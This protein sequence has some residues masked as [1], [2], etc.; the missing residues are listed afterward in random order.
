VAAH[1]TDGLFYFGRGWQEEVGETFKKVM[2]TGAGGRT[3]IDY[4][5][6]VEGLALLAGAKF[7]QAGSPLELFTRLVNEVRAC[8]PPPTFSPTARPT[9]CPLLRGFRLEPPRARPLSTQ[10]RLAAVSR[11]GAAACGGG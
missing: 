1:S 8:H 5:D 6:F 4:A 7:A 11:G 3:F 2:Q 10:E 9:V